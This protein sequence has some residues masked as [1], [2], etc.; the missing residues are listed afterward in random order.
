MLTPPSYS[1]IIHHLKV[2][3]GTVMLWQSGLKNNV[4]VC[5]YQ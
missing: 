2:M 3:V 5:S 1:Q 4:N